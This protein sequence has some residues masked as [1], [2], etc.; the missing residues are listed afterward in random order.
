VLREAPAAAEDNAARGPADIVA[1]MD[2]AAGTGAE[3]SAARGWRGE[4]RAQWRLAAPVVLVQVGLFA[5][6]FVDN[7]MVGHV[8]TD[9]ATQMA[10]TALGSLYT[11]VV[12]AFGMGTLMALDP[13]V[14]QAFGAG[15]LAAVTRDVQR[16]VVLALL[17]SL[18]AALLLQFAEPV[19]RALGQQPTA[20]PV[21]AAY[22][23][24]A[25]PGVPAFLLFVVLRQ[26]LQALHR[27]RPI[28]VTV[29]VANV[30]NAVLDW[31]FVRGELG[32]PALGGVGCAIAT[33]LC[34]WLMLVL[35]LVGAW[36]LLA[37]HLR[38]MRWREAARG[39][40]L[41]ALLRLGLPNGAM[42]DLEIA[43]F[44]AVALWMNYLGDAQLAGHQVALNLAA[45]AFM[46]PLG[47]SAAAAV[48]VGHAIGR[49]DAHGARLAGNVA[50]GTGALVMT[51]SAAL[52]ALVPRT[53]AGI[54]T[55]E[56]DIIALAAVL[57]PIAAVFQVFDGVQI[58][59][60]GVLRGTGD[61]RTPMLVYF[62]GYWAFGLPLAWWLG[63]RCGYGP[64][65]MWWS[66]V[67]AL[68]AVALVLVLRARARLARPLAR[69]S[70]EGPN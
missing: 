23:R 21:A 7:V 54:Y 48:R 61:T 29:L 25:V 37:P 32:L 2:A 46:V 34:R 65:G 20:I 50:I 36:P 39:Q 67:A 30:A 16:G 40:P 62:I 26:T 27:L 11:W 52:F 56:P 43:A 70:V 44:G 68:A 4:A 14:A 59:A 13:L 49:G 60:N 19:L 53:L 66:L 8:E 57:L 3:G 22:A 35:L 18:P 6:G 47:I 51:V 5:M 38:P 10:G 42:V 33:S 55:D 69:T 1:P 17:M 45:L 12:L 64:A 63:L 15:D 28:V 41:L 9:V 24:W 31:G 58:A